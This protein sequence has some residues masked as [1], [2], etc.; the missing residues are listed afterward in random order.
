[1]VFILDGFD[2]LSD[3]FFEGVNP[4]INAIVWIGWV[5]IGVELEL[6]ESGLDKLLDNHAGIKVGY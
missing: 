5:I 1:M 2:G 6:N 4:L 3:F